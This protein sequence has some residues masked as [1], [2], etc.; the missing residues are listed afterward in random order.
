ML[1]SVSRRHRTLWAID[2]SEAP[3]HPCA[4]TRF[5][6]GVSQVTQPCYL[7]AGAQGTTIRV[8]IVFS[9]GLFEGTVPP[10]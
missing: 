2:V 1:G 5:R 6:R 7:H 10:A 3:G 8:M 9:V 4:T